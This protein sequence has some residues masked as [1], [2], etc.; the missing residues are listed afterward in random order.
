MPLSV[1]RS[2]S[3]LPLEVDA[4]A[5][6]DAAGTAD[7][8][9]QM[10]R[11]VLPDVPRYL[12]LGKG[13]AFS[14]TDYMLTQEAMKQGNYLSYEDTLISGNYH[15]GILTLII[16]FGIFGLLS[17]LWFCVA[18]VRVLYRNYCYGAESLKLINTFLLAYFC[19]RLV[20]Y[21]ALYGQFD[22]DL[23]L[24]TGT[25]G[26][27]VALNGGVKTRETQESEET[28]EVEEAVPA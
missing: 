24:F 25:V 28:V 5:Y 12:L 23:V 2:L 9:F 1:Q 14:G 18:A 4:M 26:L 20:F 3:F 13:F 17:F 22:L 27:S 7:W 16:P 8:R 15:H 6:Q 21:L 10:W 19:A 11:A